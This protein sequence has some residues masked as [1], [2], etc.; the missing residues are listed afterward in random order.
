MFL[1]LKNRDTMNKNY[2]KKVVITM[3]VIIAS[4]N[5]K[6]QWFMGGVIGLYVESENKKGPN[7]EID[8]SQITQTLDNTSIGFRIA[9][10]GGYYFNEKFAL[11]LMLSVGG[12]FY[13]SKEKCEHPDPRWCKDIKY[14]KNSFDWGIY[15][16]V[17]YS[18]FT[19]KKFSVLLEGYTGV[20]CS[21]GFGK[22]NH[23]GEDIENKKESTT[24]S[25][26]VFNV[27]PILSFKFNDRLQ[28]EAGLRFLNLGYN[29]NMTKEK[30]YPD[31]YSRAVEKKFNRI[32][33]DFNIGFNSGSIFTLS[34]LTIGVIYKFPARPN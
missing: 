24:I 18:V 15:P 31:A 3:L 11:G 10:T 21:H 27:R 2:F 26:A 19:Y 17:R 12:N 13:E 30:K 25:I 22:L 6:A 33:H 23:V 28:M 29:I 4:V 16:L 9:P 14:R 34:Q 20:G 7:G 1:K 8:G 32:R 5:V